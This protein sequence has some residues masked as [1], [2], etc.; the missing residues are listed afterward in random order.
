MS[1]PVN[2]YQLLGVSSSADADTIKRAYH[3]KMRQYHPDQ[4]IARRKTLEQ[5]RDYGALVRLDREVAQ[6][7]HQ[8][9]QINAAYAVL[10][11]NAR[12][13]EYDLR[14]QRP[15]TVATASVVP[16]DEPRT[17]PRQR[18][19][20]APATPPKPEQFPRVLAGVF[21]VGLTI[22]M[23]VISGFF[24][25]SSSSPQQAGFRLTQTIA[26]IP[27]GSM[28]ATATARAQQPTST[29]RSIASY[30]QAAENFAQQELFNLAE[31]QYSLALTIATPTEQ[32][33]IYYQRGQLRALQNN[34]RGAIEDFDQVIAFD[35]QYTEAYRERGWLY[36]QRWQE[37]KA[38]FSPL[39]PPNYQRTINE[40][41]AS[42]R[43]DLTRY[44]EL[45]GDAALVATALAALADD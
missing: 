1:K 36:L 43:A 28:D 6:A 31:T 29:P 9:Q 25:P 19:H 40:L 7:Q 21:I 13:A 42:A 23:S 4:F 12:R 24:R 26:Y 14:L 18:P 15:L 11:D 34:W 3:A 17:T 30:L 38:L 39:P 8:A 16:A 35:P 27:A 44:V 10:S 41:A 5:K 32:A 37:E 45:G 2:H 22:A 20:R 33:K